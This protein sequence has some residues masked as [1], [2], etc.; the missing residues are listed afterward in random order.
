MLTY[1]DDFKKLLHI[2]EQFEHVE[3][4][5]PNACLIKFLCC[6]TGGSCSF[7]FCGKSIFCAKS[8]VHL[9]HVL[10]C[11]VMDNADILRCFCHFC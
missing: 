1:A 11:N 4:I 9:G 10:T 2:C 7:L 5:K 8:V 3:V 6:C